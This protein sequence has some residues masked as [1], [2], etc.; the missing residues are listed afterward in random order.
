MIADFEEPGDADVLRKVLGDLTG[1]GIAT[2][3]HKGASRDDPPARGSQNAS[4]DRIERDYW[5]KS[6]GWHC[7]IPV[8]QQHKTVQLLQQS[9]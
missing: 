2:D 3:E 9:R 7:E 4:F 5:V 8:R 1:K 6:T